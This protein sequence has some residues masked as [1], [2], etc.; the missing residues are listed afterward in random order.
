MHETSAATTQPPIKEALGELTE[1]VE[2]ITC[3]DLVLEVED[4]WL[5]L[6][7]SHLLG[8]KLLRSSLAVGYYPITV[9]QGLKDS[10]P[11]NMIWKG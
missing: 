11:S 5:I 4:S 1:R 8:S 3:L 10:K 6:L 9:N 2:R 7:H